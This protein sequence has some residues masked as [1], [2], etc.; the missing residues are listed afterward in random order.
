MSANRCFETLD[1]TVVS[2][3]DKT[4]ARR[5]ETIYSEMQRNSSKKGPNPIKKNGYRYNKNFISKRYKNPKD[6]SSYQYRLASAKSYDLLLD[7]TK[8]KRFSNPVN[9]VGHNRY[10]TWGGNVMQVDYKDKTPYK[11]LSWNTQQNNSNTVHMPIEIDVTVSNEVVDK[12]HNIFYS[13]CY[14]TTPSHIPPWIQNVVTKTPIYKNSYY[15]YQGARAD[16]FRG[17]AYPEEIYFE[18]Q[19]PCEQ[20]DT[21]CPNNSK[22]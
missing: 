8:G 9:N 13:S 4:N 14:F 15:Y 1:T 21:A 2:G 3:S 12:D 7:I 10:K 17:M 20:D 22:C 5:Q 6:A 11:M 19:K 18:H 16:P